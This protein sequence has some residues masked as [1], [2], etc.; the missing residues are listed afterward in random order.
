MASA[1]MKDNAVRPMV[2][3]LKALCQYT[4]PATEMQSVDKLTAKFPNE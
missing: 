4:S 1:M 2:D 3:P